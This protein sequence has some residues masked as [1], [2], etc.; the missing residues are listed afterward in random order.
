[1]EY[2]ISFGRM[3]VVNRR[4]WAQTIKYHQLQPCDGSIAAHSIY[5]HHQFT[6]PA[7]LLSTNENYDRYMEKIKGNGDQGES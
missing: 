4:S 5:V 2:E 3:Q 1:M 7:Y 6:L